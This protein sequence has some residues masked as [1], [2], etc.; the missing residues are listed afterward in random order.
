MFDELKNALNT[1]NLMQLKGIYDKY[2]SEIEK[3]TDFNKLKSQLLKTYKNNLIRILKEDTKAKA[4][5]LKLNYKSFRTF[6]DELVEYINKSKTLFHTSSP[7]EHQV[8]DQE[9]YTD[10][11][12]TPDKPTGTSEF[13]PVYFHESVR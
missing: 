13:G 5:E 9:R 3:L 4:S 2:K 8:I 11:S 12:L 7:L 6:I 1:G 10:P